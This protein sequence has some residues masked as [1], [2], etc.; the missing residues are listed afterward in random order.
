MKGF[1]LLEE[2]APCLQ[3]LR[4]RF[5][6]LLLFGLRRLDRFG[7][8]LGVLIELLAGCFDDRDLRNAVVVDFIRRRGFLLLKLCQFCLCL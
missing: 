3:K 7:D 2:C 8:F 1:D 6:R 4:E 5:L